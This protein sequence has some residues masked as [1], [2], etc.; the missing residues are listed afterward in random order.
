MRRQTNIICINIL[1]M[2]LLGGFSLYAIADQ[3]NEGIMEGKDRISNS[4]LLRFLEQPPRITAE[5]WDMAIAASDKYP[6]QLIKPPESVAIVRPAN[7]VLVCHDV[8]GNLRWE[9]MDDPTRIPLGKQDRVVFA[10]AEEAID[11][12]GSK[13]MNLHVA[14]FNTGNNALASLAAHAMYV[15]F[16]RISTVDGIQP[17]P[18]RDASLVSNLGGEMNQR[19][20]WTIGN[21]RGEISTKGES[22]ENYFANAFL[23]ETASRLSVLFDPPPDGAAEADPAGLRIETEREG[24][25]W[26]VVAT[27]PEDGP[28]SD[29]WLRLDTSQGEVEVQAPGQALVKGASV[30]GATV[31]VHAISPDGK[32]W[33]R[34]S[35][36]IRSGEREGK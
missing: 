34:M 22:S 5:E 12:I 19:L 3:N 35:A 16:S 8:D 6:M 17:I 29:W 28:Y 10:R 25:N 33:R 26:R 27:T 4:Q 15:R 31:T 23:G 1:N 21:L 36:D 11:V 24:E 18:V 13:R 9:R 20:L 32:T 7:S 2:V 30:T 14:F